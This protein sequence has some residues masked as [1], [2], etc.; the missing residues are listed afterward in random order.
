MFDLAAALPGLLPKAIAWAESES[1][2]IIA[3]GIPLSDFGRKLAHL[4]DVRNPENI[5]ILEVPVIP[6]PEDPELRQAALATGMLG[7][8]T[9]GL[10]LGYG[11]YLVRGHKTNRLLSHEC[12]HVYQYEVAGSIRAFLPQYLRQIAAFGYEGAPYEVDARAY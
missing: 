5:R 7:A 3:K 6:V 9:I 4:V 2:Q 12:R 11:I 8:N 10:T 1:A